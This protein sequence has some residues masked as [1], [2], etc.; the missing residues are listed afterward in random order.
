[1]V[2]A[3]Q[4]SSASLHSSSLTGQT[5]KIWLLP[6]DVQTGSGRRILFQAILLCAIKPASSP[7]TCNLQRNGFWKI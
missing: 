6:F 1:M 2:I 4:I 3:F 5:L 7:V